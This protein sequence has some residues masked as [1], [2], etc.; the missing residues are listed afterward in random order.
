MGF[1][2]KCSGFG[3]RLCQQIFVQLTHQKSVAI[4]PYSAPNYM[5]VVAQMLFVPVVQPQ[6]LHSFFF[7]LKKANRSLHFLVA[8]PMYAATATG[9]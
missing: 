8:K 6:R 3:K 7:S 4:V 9:P 1:C 2:I 5:Q